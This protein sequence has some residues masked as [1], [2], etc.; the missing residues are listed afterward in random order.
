MEQDVAI[1]KL[2]KALAALPPSA[3]V[4]LIDFVNYLQFKY[5]TN[6]EKLTHADVAVAEGSNGRSSNT[7][8]ADK[9]A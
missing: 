8:S 9:T 2:R 5:Q 7:V 1:H 4:E 3:H 6:G